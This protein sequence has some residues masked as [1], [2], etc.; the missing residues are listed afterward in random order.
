MSIKLDYSSPAGRLIIEQMNGILSR[1]RMFFNEDMDC[2][3]YTGMRETKARISIHL[4]NRV[5]DLL[6]VNSLQYEA[7][8]GIT[9]YGIPTPAVP[10][11][12]IEHIMQRNNCKYVTYS[13]TSNGSVLTISH[14]TDLDRYARHTFNVA[15]DSPDLLRDVE[16]ALNN[17]KKSIAT[18]GKR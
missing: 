15:I 9:Y 2:I 8:V 7:G 3:C 14:N 4:S 6:S 18:R 17:L 5:C 1:V 11:V 12:E 16:L 13:V 10:L